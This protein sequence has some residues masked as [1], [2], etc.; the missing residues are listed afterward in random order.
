MSLHNIF[1]DEKEVVSNGT[2][3]ES[4]AGNL[5]GFMDIQIYSWGGTRKK[6]AV[7]GGGREGY[8]LPYCLWT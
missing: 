7:D 6:T 5:L 8:I 4:E 3:W 1:K 2:L